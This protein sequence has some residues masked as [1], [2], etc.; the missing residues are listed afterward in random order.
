MTDKAVKDQQ[1][2]TPDGQ[3]VKRMIDGVQLRRAITHSDE[4][5]TVTEIFSLPWG[6]QPDPVT[7]I[8]QFTIRPGWVKGWGVH[9]QKT[10]RLF[11]SQGTVKVVLFD[12]RPDSPTYQLL[13]E[14]YISEYER[15]LLIIPIG[16]YHA[17][18][19]VSD[20]EALIISLPTTA[21]DHADPDIYRLPPNND[22][23][24]YRFDSNKWGW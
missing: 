6:I 1:T 15:A 9:Y 8:Y 7:H 23:I 12:D 21:Y 10:D 17:L 13:D 5:G 11:L 19:C 4:R 3:R 18:Q 14:F 24:P 20:T 22:Y 2:V 16:V